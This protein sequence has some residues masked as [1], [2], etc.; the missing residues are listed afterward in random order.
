MY[1]FLAKFIKYFS[2]KIRKINSESARVLLGF[3][4]RRGRRGG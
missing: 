4:L 3:E 2:F 1:I